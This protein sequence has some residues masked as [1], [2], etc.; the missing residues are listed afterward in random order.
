M[1][2]TALPRT[3]KGPRPQYFENPA[4]DQLHAIVLAMSAEI[5]VLY[6]RC[7]ALERMLAAKGIVEPGAVDSYEPGEP[8]REERALKREALINRLFRAVR[9]DRERLP[10]EAGTD[11]PSS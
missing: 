1:S 4:I 9:E 11:A 5:A 6:D 8:A 2:K 3:A 7:D 10:D